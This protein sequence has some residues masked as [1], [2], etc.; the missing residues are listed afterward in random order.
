MGFNSAFKGL[1]FRFT[2]KSEVKQFLNYLLNVSDTSQSLTE[3]KHLLNISV[4][5]WMAFVVETRPAEGQLRSLQ[6][7]IKQT[8]FLKLLFGTRRPTVSKQQQQQ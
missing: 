7:N 3:T 4:S 2:T 1:Q 5:L 6:V 8:K